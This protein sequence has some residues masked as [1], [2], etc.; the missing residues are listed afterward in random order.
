METEP[1]FD[2]SFVGDSHHE[3]RQSGPELAEDGVV[4]GPEKIETRLLRG[5]TGVADFVDVSTPIPVLAE[6]APQWLHAVEE[7][8]P[9]L[10]VVIRRQLPADGGEGG[11][12]FLQLVPVVGAPPRHGQSRV[13]GGEDR[14]RVRCRPHPGH[15]T[16]LL[17]ALEPSVNEAVPVPV[18][19]PGDLDQVVACQPDRESLDQRG[20][21]V[22]VGQQGVGEALEAGVEVGALGGLVEHVEPRRDSGGHRV[23]DENALGEGVQRADG[24]FVDF[25]ASGDEARLVRV[26][27][28]DGFDPLPDALAQLGRGRFGESDGGDLAQRGAPAPH[29]LDDP[30]H[31]GRGLPRARTRHHHQGG[32]EVELDRSPGLVVVVQ[33]RHRGTPTSSNPSTTA[34]SRSSGTSACM[35]AR[36]GAT[37]GSLLLRAHCRSLVTGHR[38]SKSHERH[39][40]N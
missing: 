3:A 26:V 21:G 40:S 36:T 30:A 5:R 8:Q 11:E 1:S 15:R 16:D 37:S 39:A 35:S 10:L 34:P 18:Q 13:D 9:R 24:G 6:F 27:C 14:S 31:E 19:G 12:V 2:P 17:E 20:L 4:T 7:L 29:E 38:T 23:L 28:G 25:L 22:R 32:V 33:G